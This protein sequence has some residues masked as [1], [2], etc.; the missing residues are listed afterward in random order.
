[1]EDQKIVRWL[2]ADKCEDT[3]GCAWELRQPIYP[4][5]KMAWVMVRTCNI[6]LFED[7]PWNEDVI[8]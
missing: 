6:H 8:G 2:T 4:G 3:C 7:H 5:A 1:M